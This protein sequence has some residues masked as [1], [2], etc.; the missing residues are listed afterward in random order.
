MGKRSKSRRKVNIQNVSES[1][2]S[3]GLEPKTIVVMDGNL[4]GLYYFPTADEKAV[5]VSA[6]APHDLDEMD[7]EALT[8][9]R[10]MIASLTCNDIA[11]MFESREAGLNYIERDAIALTDL[12]IQLNSGEYMT[13]FNF[14]NSKITSYLFSDV[15]KKV[16]HGVTMV[17]FLRNEQDGLDLLNY[18]LEPSTNNVYIYGK[19]VLPDGTEVCKPITN[20]RLSLALVAKM[21]VED[22]VL[23]KRINDNPEEFGSYADYLIDGS[24]LLRKIAT[25]EA[26]EREA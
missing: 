23:R 4:I 16:F 18:Y 12:Q 22:M 8:E 6:N 5:I 25:I 10:A 13:A 24:F 20:T 1:Q 11:K 7:I 19:D 26:E 15:C 17:G 3:E 14:G 9:T 2:F 21:T